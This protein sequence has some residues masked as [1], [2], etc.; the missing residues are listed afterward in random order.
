MDNYR[1]LPDCLTIKQSAIE[2]L[3]LFASKDI[4]KDTDL[5]ISHTDHVGLGLI[6]HPLGSFYNHS[7]EPNCIKKETE[8]D[9][10]LNIFSQFNLITL[11]D[12]KAGEELTVNYT[13]ACYY[14]GNKLSL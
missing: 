6:R 9:C 14:K 10:H 1:P 3:G 2:G 12:I 8:F 11:R 4:P 7:E 13:F 5:G